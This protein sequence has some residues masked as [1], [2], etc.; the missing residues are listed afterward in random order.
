MTRAIGERL[1]RAKSHA[2]RRE[3]AEDWSSSWRRDHEH[4]LRK[5]ELALSHG[6]I[7]E[8]GRYLGQLKVLNDK[9]MSTLSRVFDALGSRDDG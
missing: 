4:T 1:R 7:E 6:E 3:I 8:A 5:V 2:T 9:A